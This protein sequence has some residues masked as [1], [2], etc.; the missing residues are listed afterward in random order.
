MRRDVSDQKLFADET[1]GQTFRGNYDFRLEPLRLEA[2]KTIQFWIEVKDNKQP[3]ANRANTPRINV[4]IGN[5]ASAEAVKQEL[6]K[7]K[8]KQQEEL[9][10]ADAANN[11]DK[12]EDLPPPRN[13]EDDAKP[14]DPQPRPEPGEDPQKNQR[15]DAERESEN[16]QDPQDQANDEQQSGQQKKSTPDDF[17]Q[18]LNKL[19]QKEQQKQEA[20]RSKTTTKNNSPV[21]NRI[22][23]KRAPQIK[24]CRQV[25]RQ[26]TIAKQPSSLGEAAIR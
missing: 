15:R 22:L 25:S 8:Q 1:L 3:T 13:N 18:A 6:E 20:A 17:Q 26:K 4:H 23:P 16:A 11:P 9:N 12:V 14:A 21:T 19:L 10:R 7:E 24:R 5:P 2:G